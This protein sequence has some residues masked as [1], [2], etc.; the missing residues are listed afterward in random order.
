M[1]NCFSVIEK[2]GCNGRALDNTCTIT[3]HLSEFKVLHSLVVLRICNGT[4]TT[5]HVVG[6]YWV[7]GHAAVRG[8]EKADELTRGGSD[9]GFLGPEPALGSL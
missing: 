2:N 8:N 3:L 1:Y 7:P 5:R 4:N 6:L 9:L